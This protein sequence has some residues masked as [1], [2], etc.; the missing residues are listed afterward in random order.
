MS[1]LMKRYVKYDPI[2]KKVDIIGCDTKLT[3]N[4]PWT[5]NQNANLQL[6]D[7]KNVLNKSTTPPKTL[8]P[9][10]LKYEIR[11]DNKKEGIKDV[12][13]D[14]VQLKDFKNKQVT[15]SSILKLECDGTDAGNVT[16][17]KPY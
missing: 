9:A 16:N 4:A 5:A 1:F 8:T 12:A 11:G 13:N 6:R 3:S 14:K 17:I 7:K 15:V 2:A 10:D